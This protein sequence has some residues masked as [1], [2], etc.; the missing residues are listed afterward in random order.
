[1]ALVT[2]GVPALMRSGFQRCAASAASDDMAISAAAIRRAYEHRVQPH[3]H[4]TP[5]LQS[6]QMNGRVAGK[7]FFLKAEHLQ[8][9]GAFKIRGAVNAVA[10]TEAAVVVTQSSGNHAQAL[11]LAAQLVNKKAIIVMPSNSPSVKVDAVR[12]SYGAEVRFCEPT[13]EAREA[14]SA[15]I[16]ASMQ[17]ELG[18]SAVEEIHP[19]QDPR[20]VNGQGTIAIEL[21]EQMKELDQP[22]DAVV[23]SIGGGGLIG[24]IATFIKEVAPHIKIIGAE[25]ER[26]CSAHDTLKAG[27][28]V[29]NP[30]NVAI[31]SI[32]DSIKSSL[33]ATTCPIVLEH[34]DDVITASEDEIAEA[35]KFTMERTK[36]VI[37][38]GCGAAVAVALSDKFHQ[39]HPELKNI[40]VIMC[41]GNVDLADL[42]WNK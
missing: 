34:V 3:V 27:H 17:A 24:G 29:T 2:R 36:Q 14:M 18:K 7:R 19:N 28:L 20:V 5:V 38:A 9:V 35:M 13:Q 8:R 30:P 37:E 26:A 31:E 1:M 39:A 40:G 15:E 22:L 21:L 12:D 10:L 4:R 41:G 23:V 33:G 11:A 42:P 16:V 32:A 6:D 25:A